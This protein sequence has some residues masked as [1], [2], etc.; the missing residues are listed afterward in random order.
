MVFGL[1]KARSTVLGYPL[2]HIPG[3]TMDGFLGRGAYF[4]A[5][6]AAPD[7]EVAT[8]PRPGVQLPES[9]SLREVA[10]DGNGLF[11]AIADQLRSRPGSRAATGELCTHQ[12]LHTLAVSLV[13]G[14]PRFRQMLSDREWFDLAGVNGY[15]DV[16]SV[17][18]L[19]RALLHVNI[20]MYGAP[21]GVPVRNDRNNG[22]FDQETPDCP[23]LRVACNGGHRCAS[24]VAVSAS[25]QQQEVVRRPRSA[26]KKRFLGSPQ[27]ANPN[28]K[29]SNSTP[30]QVSAAIKTFPERHRHMRDHDR[31]VLCELAPNVNVPCVVGSHDDLPEGPALI[32]GPAGNRVV[33][34][35]NGVRTHVLPDCLKVLQVVEEAHTKGTNA[36][37]ISNS[38]TL[39]GVLCCVRISSKRVSKTKTPV[40]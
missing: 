4:T 22:T 26:E 24:V 13:D 7:S 8:P 36:T 40:S 18:A 33:P 23:V 25:A 5:L 11:H 21:G 9:F 14:E 28:N 20:A 35:G 27:A 15:V 19:A 39:C 2:V 32:V 6:Q 10:G 16:W 29:R 1:M 38:S 17:A 37:F 34:A 30:Q 3:F 31:A 12:P